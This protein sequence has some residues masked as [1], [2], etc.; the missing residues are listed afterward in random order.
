MRS[1]VLVVG[2]VAMDLVV[3]VAEYPPRGG[4]A[5]SAA[6][7]RHPGGSAANTAVN[8]ARMGT[9]VRFLG[10][11]A[12]DQEGEALMAD[13]RAEGIEVVPHQLKVGAASPIVI[14][15]VDGDGERTLISASR[16][17]AQTMLEVG[18][19]TDDVFDGVVWVHVSGVALVEQPGRAALIAALSAARALGLPCSFDVNLRLDGTAFDEALG[20][21]VRDCIELSTV[22]LASS[23][24][25]MTLA[26]DRDDAAARATALADGRRTAVIRLGAAGAMAVDASGQDWRDSGRSGT[27]VDT[28]GAGDAFD[29][30]F[31]RA[32]LDGAGL[33]ACLRWG[34]AAAALKSRHRGGRGFPGLAALAELA[35]LAH[36]T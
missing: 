15:I 23:V 18:E 2:D 24:E 9:E 13:M 36:E 20:Q 21:A 29:A 17:S 6:P 27:A 25:A 14:A 12:D 5:W 10:R 19:I 33:Q 1:G 26:P 8:L 22:V 31:I 7:E 34:N 3:R 28:L 30:G 11:F 32:S 16:G 4:N 35:E